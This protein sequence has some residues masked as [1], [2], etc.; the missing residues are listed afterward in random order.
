M[1]TISPNTGVTTSVQSLATSAAGQNG[2]DFNMFLKLLTSQMQNQ[3]PLKPMDATEYTQ[4]LVQY[5]QVEQSLQQTGVLKDILASLSSQN[6]TMAASFIGKE[7]TFDGSIAGLDATG[8]SASW[9][10]AASRPVVTMQAVITDASGKTVR[11][12]DL[13]PAL[14]GRVTWDGMTFAGSRA[15]A[16][17]YS[18]SIVGKDANGDVVPVSVNALGTVKTISKENNQVMV[19]TGGA[20]LPLNSLLALSEVAG[21]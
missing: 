8:G 11:Q 5:S 9:T 18:L 10:Y 6:L 13:D 19:G 20:N 17:P 7:A 1:T 4:Q 12:I 3:D 16:G 2:K 14:N 15:A 21:K